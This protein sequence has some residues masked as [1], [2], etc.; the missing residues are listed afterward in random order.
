MEHEEIEREHLEDEAREARLRAAL[1]QA[2]QAY[3]EALRALKALGREIGFPLSH[4]VR[5]EDPNV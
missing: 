4:S 2:D 3:A 5:M 1:D